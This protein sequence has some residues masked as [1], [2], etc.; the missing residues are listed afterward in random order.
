MVHKVKNKGQQP[1]TTYSNCIAIDISEVCARIRMINH[2]IQLIKGKLPLKWSHRV[3]WSSLNN[4]V[5]NLSKNQGRGEIR[6]LFITFGHRGEDLPLKPRIS[7]LKHTL[8]GRDWPWKPRGLPHRKA[9]VLNCELLP[10]ELVKN[11]GR[12]ICRQ[13]K[14]HVNN[15]SHLTH[16]Y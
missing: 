6:E 15:S 8:W 13:R 4:P 11:Q 7:P 5:I 1:R 2:H 14:S 3:E 12:R 10:A 16:N 9:A